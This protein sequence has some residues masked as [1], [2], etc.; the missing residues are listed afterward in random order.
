[1]RKKDEGSYILDEPSRKLNGNL[2]TKTPN[3]EIYA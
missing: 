1:M 2:Y 3:R